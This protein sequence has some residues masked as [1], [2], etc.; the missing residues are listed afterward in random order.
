[1][2]YI[3]TVKVFP[4]WFFSGGRK[5]TA[6]DPRAKCILGKCNGY[7]YIKKNGSYV[8]STDSFENASKSFIELCNSDIKDEHVKAKILHTFTE[9]N[10]FMKN[11]PF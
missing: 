5:Q 8:Y 10:E 11:P 3:E 7:F 2:K 9:F 6:D 4:K 1:M